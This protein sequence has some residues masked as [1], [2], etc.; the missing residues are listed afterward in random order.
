MTPTK[1]DDLYYLTGRDGLMH[2]AKTFE[3]HKKN[4]ALY[5]D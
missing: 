3:E 2:Y 1:T 4:R 5:L